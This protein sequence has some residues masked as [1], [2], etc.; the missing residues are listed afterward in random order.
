MR[1]MVQNHP[2]QLLTMMAMEPLVSFDADAVRDEKSK[3]LKAVQPFTA[4]TV[5]KAVRGQY[6][7]GT[8]NGAIVPA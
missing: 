5:R 4:E 8:V 1:D 2:F 6:G 7:E 3:L